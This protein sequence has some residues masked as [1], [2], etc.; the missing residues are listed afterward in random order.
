MIKLIASDVDGTLVKDSS[1]IIYNEIPETIIRLKKEKQIQFTVASGRSYHS[2]RRMFRSVSEDIAYIA[3]NG[4]HIIYQ[5]ETLFLKEM[6]RKDAED[7]VKM[8]RKYANQCEC[9]VSTPEGTLMETDNREFIEL[10]RNGYRNKYEIVEDVLATKLPIIKVSIYQKEGIRQLGEEVF[11]PAFSQR[12]KGT[13]AGEQWVDFMDKTV[14]KGDALRYLQEYFGVTKEE[15][16]AFG[17]NNNDI[18]M[19]M[20]A[21]E[22]YAVSNARDEVKASAKHICPSYHEKGVYQVISKLL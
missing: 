18:G 1:P 20:A 9:I 6:K 8:Y 2:I 17:D 22:S 13:M 4:A 11:I 21:G 7:I 16:M 19:L 14:D 15:T 5:G 10:I 12:V 3:E